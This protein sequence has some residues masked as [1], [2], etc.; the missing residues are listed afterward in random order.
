MRTLVIAMVAAF[1]IAGHRSHAVADAPVGFDH[2]SHEKKLANV[3][4]IA[5]STCHNEQRGKLVGRPGHGTC[6]GA[7]HGPAPV[8]PPR[9]SK[10]SKGGKVSF[11]DRAR[12]CASCHAPSLDGT[13]VTGTLP[14]AYPPY[15]LAPEHVATF[16]H[17]RHAGVA[18]TQCH[19][20]RVSSRTP[21]PT[22]ERC[23]GCHDGSGASGRG[24]AMSKCSTC[25]VV[26]P[27][28][29]AP[30][31]A[32]AAFSHSR[33]ATRGTAGK[34]C[35]Q[36]HREVTTT[37]SLRV[38]LPTMQSCATA[39]CH[40][41]KG[42]FAT[43][44]SC[45]RCHDKAPANYEVARPTKRFLH[46]GAHTDVV[47]KQPCTSCHALGTRGDP[48]VAGHTA[49]ANPAC[50]AVDFAA[51]EPLICGA[52]HNATEPWRPLVADRGP[53]DR[54][55]FGAMLDHDKHRGE[56]ARC[57]SLRTP[58]S[59]L[60]PA[61]GHA[62]CT[63]SGC[64]A[65]KAGPTPMLGACD[66]CH[67]AGLAA[68]RETVRLKAPWSV[69][70]RFD[71]RTHATE[72]GTDKPR[73]CASCHTNISGTDLVKLATPPKATCAPCHDAKKTAFKLTGTSCGRCHLEKR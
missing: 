54:T 63:G 10:G 48:L 53:A 58:S 61:R 70:A 9:G 5:C 66:G 30:D 56:C 43:T 12:I 39:S 20:P 21:R 15:T 23:L 24:P 44:A 57:H 62:A 65:E 52:C 41:G 8:A 69:R 13:V 31:R 14:V 49:C 64:H 11:G 51:R 45:N 38:P 22:H 72:P 4:T 2:V 6:F 73:P 25:H 19:D 26:V 3:G 47:D 36:C 59:Q 60:R 1:A 37:D 16:G 46:A 32:P 18:C 67:R 7:C 28:S 35:A 71:H 55:E 40:D 33:H 34:E 29:R 27:A 42:A 68:E 17:K 50:H